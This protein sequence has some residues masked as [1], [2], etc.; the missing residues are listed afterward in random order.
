MPAQI[1]SL[2]ETDAVRARTSKKDPETRAA[3]IRKFASE[4][5]LEW[6]AESGTK[7]TREPRGSLVATEVMLYAEGGSFPCSLI[8]RILGKC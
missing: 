6:I 1:A 3:E 8:S 7:V 5:L 4:A 2:E